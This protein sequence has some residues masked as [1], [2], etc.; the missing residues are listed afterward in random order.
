[1]NRLSIEKR[2]QIIGMMVEGVSIRSISRMTGASKNTIVKLLA[3]AGQACLNYQDRAFHGLS[4]KRLQ[5][6][7]IWAFVGMK[8]KNV[9]D[10][11]RG[12]G[13]VGDIWT[14]TAI[15][16][17]SKLIPSWMVG[18]RSGDTAKIFVR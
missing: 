18:D 14:W 16:A 1:M 17:D 12:K 15:D 13:T 3:Y 8:E 4:C 6:D 10:N 11:L 7:E 5:L 2:A 9:P